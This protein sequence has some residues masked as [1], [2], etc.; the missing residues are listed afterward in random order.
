MCV[1]QNNCA[2]VTGEQFSTEIRKLATACNGSPLLA[3]LCAAALANN[4]MPV[5]LLL[6]TLQTLSDDYEKVGRSVDTRIWLDIALLCTTHASS[7]IPY[8]ANSSDQIIATFE[9]VKTGCHA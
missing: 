4:A 9:C 6:S 8:K 7:A 2:Q 3:Q 5:Q 1:K